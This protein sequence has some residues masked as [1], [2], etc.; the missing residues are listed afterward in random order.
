MELYT[1]F[2][3]H[4]LYDIEHS[5]AP[6]LMKAKKMLKALHSGRVFSFALEY[7]TPTEE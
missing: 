3:D 5:M 6:E 1:H 2:T 7:I 4:I